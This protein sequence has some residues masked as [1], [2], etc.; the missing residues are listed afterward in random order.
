MQA[1]QWTVWIWR[2]KGFAVGLA[3]LLIFL[4]A[5][6]L[7]PAL[8]PYDPNVPDYKATLAG[9]SLRHPFGTDEH[10]R[11]LLTRLM[12]GTRISFATAAVAVGIATILGLPLGL[13]AGY[14]GN[15]YDA[16]VG[17]LMDTLFAFPPVLMALAVS[18]VLGPS[19]R[20][21]M[22]AIGLF[23]LPEFARVARSAMVSTKESTYVDASRAVGTPVVEI[24][25]RTIL[26]N[27]LGPILVLISL[28]FGYAIL[29]E[30]ALS[31]LGI[32]A[33][34]PTPSFG[35]VLSGGKRYLAEAPW[36]S[37]FPGLTIF[38]MVGAS[39]LI[40]DGLRDLA[41]PRQRRESGQ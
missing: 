11:D 4:L 36:Y 22:I 37:I 38:L 39:N 40:S 3:I 31:F 14:F 10:G 25:F 19:V 34:P 26:P 12:Y 6:I 2:R 35:Y 15:W 18:A 1:R 32:G 41:D 16:L 17:R 30:A 27:C 23:S 21:A 28:G 20:S 8:S 33:Q 9:P 5:A 7:A 24:L 13:T 29:N